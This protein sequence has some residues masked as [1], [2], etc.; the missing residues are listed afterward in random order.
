LKLYHGTSAKRVWQITKKGIRPRS[1]TGK[2][3]W[4]EVPEFKSRNDMVYLTSCYP[5][6]FA[7]CCTEGNRIGIVEIDTDKLDVNKLFPD[8]DVIAQILS[9]QTGVSLKETHSKVKAKLLYMHDQWETS[10]Q[11]MGTCCYHGLILPE[12]LTRYALIDLKGRGQLMLSMLDPAIAIRNYQIKGEY[13]KAFV[14]WVFGD[15]EILP[16]YEE[17]KMFIDAGIPGLERQFKFWEE[18]QSNRNG[19]VVVELSKGKKK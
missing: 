14:A 15:R 4:N 13:Y 18:Q 12:A 8:E 17:T 1:L 6:Y 5:L 9:E 19:I 16:Q 11:A 3:N 10:L 7:V 2:S